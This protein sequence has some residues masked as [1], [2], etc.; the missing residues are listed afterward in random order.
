MS[1]LTEWKAISAHIQGLLEAARFYIESNGPS[2]KDVHSVG[3]RRL[4]P[5]IDKIFDELERFRATH[6]E[7]I[8]SAASDSLAALPNTKKKLA[9][10]R[11]LTIDA[12]AFGYIHMMV[13]LLTS[14][15]AEFEYHL[16]DIA[17]VAKRLSE[18]AFIH[19]QR[20][21]VADE[22]FKRKW[23]KAFKEGKEPA[24]ERLGA[25]H[26]LLHGIWA[27]K[28]NTAGERTTSFSMSL[29]ESIL[30]LNELRRL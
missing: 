24:C 29:S 17:A 28:V 4:I 13:T 19:L 30:S 14:F 27:F 11:P 3:R 5:Q 1:W 26:L 20:S 12:D 8:P 25:T 10:N 23:I 22:D 7:S 2:R 6:T 16:S 21:I 18:R 9:P 15:R